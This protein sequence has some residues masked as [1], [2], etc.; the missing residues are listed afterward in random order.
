ME[1]LSLTFTKR[2]FTFLGICLGGLILLVLISILP[3]IAQKKSLEI[4]IPATKTKISQHTQLDLVVQ[5]IDK[6]LSAL[7]TIGTLPSVPVESLTITELSSIKAE[8]MGLAAEENVTFVNLNSIIP[9]SSENLKTLTFKSYLQGSLTNIRS[10]I[11]SLLQIPYI[12][13]IEQLDIQS[14]DNN[15]NL[16]LVFSVRL[17]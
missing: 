1:K 4:K 8:I 2:N 15:L 11:F 13:D 16:N 12:E 9:E 3:L 5:T 14:N 6:K 7:E 10:F 17:T